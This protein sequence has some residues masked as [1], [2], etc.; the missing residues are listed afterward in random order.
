LKG[1]F[2]ITKR[3]RFTYTVLIDKEYKFEIWIENSAEHRKLYQSSINNF[4][5]FDMTQK[6]ALKLHNLLV[7]DYKQFMKEILI[8]NKK[9]ALDKLQKEIDKLCQE[10]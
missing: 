10:K 4:I 6:Q 3:E 7:S 8:E 1:E 2:E 9:K 5:W